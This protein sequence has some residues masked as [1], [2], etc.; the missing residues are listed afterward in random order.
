MAQRLWKEG[1]YRYKRQVYDTGDRDQDSIIIS[2]SIN[3]MM[4]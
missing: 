2:I 1:S 3:V 4:K